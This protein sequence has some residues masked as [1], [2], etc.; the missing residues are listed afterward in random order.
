MEPEFSALMNNLITTTDQFI[1]GSLPVSTPSA[2]SSSQGIQPRIAPRPL[3]WSVALRS[4]RDISIQASIE[5][6]V[7]L[8]ILI[9]LICLVP[10]I[11]RIR[12]YI[13]FAD[14][15]NIDKPIFLRILA[16]PLVKSRLHRSIPQELREH[17]SPRHRRNMEFARQK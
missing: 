10:R 17:H 2:W 12:E 15:P 4:S 6:V 9:L 11:G 5:Y 7:C 3:A 8:P 14:K 1:M 13:D 16:K